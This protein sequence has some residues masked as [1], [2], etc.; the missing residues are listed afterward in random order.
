MTYFANKQGIKI[1]LLLILLISSLI[2]SCAT[3]KKYKIV[4]P[5]L[6]NESVKIKFP[7]SVVWTKIV[8]EKTKINHT[9]EWVIEGTTGLNTEWILTVSKL[10]LPKYMDSMKFIK[11]VYAMSKAT[12]TKTKFYKPKSHRIRVDDANPFFSYN[13]SVG[14]FICSNQIGKDYGTYTYQRI[15]SHKKISYAITIELRTPLDKTSGKIKFASSKKSNEF[16]QRVKESVDF[17]AKGITIENKEK[18]KMVP[19]N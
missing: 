13:S 9:R 5:E 4:L 8:D 11:S 6:S 19:L 12:C 2:T 18:G 1:Y 14:F 10:T 16:K 3:T 7:S 17:V 15:I